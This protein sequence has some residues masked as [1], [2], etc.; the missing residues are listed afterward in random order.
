MLQKRFK[1]PCKRIS[2]T[3]IQTYT[4]VHNIVVSVNRNGLQGRN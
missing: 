1:S 3:C 2:K 4:Y